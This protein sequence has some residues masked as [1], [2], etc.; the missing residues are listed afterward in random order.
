MT[1]RQLPKLKDFLPLLQPNPIIWDPTERRLSKA[2]KIE[3]LRLIAKRRTPKAIFEYVDGGSEYEAT[4]RK[5]RYLFRQL[6]LVP[7]VMV[8]VENVDTTRQILGKP[9][10][11]PWVF[12]PTG[13]TR[14]MHH[15][16]EIAVA[17][18]AER[19]GVP[20]G[21][22]VI[23]TTLIEDVAKAAPHGRNFLGSGVPADRELGKKLFDRAKANGFEALVVYVDGATPGARLRDR[24][25]GLTIPPHPTLK[26]FVDGALHPNW[27]F[28]FFTTAPISFPNVDIPPGGSVHE[29]SSQLGN[30]AASI[31][32]FEWVV[33]EW[34]G[35]VVAK[36]MATAKDARR[37]VDAGAAGVVLSAHGGRQFDQG[38]LPLRALPSVVQEVGKEAEVFIDTGIMNAADMLAAIALGAT[39]VFVGRIYLYGL[40]AGGERGVDR[41][42]EILT[43]QMI[44]IM[45][46]MG[47]T[48]LDQLT[49]DHVILP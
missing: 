45:K 22:S 39:G 33:K 32:D 6:E 10:S 42:Q 21:L 23:S 28:N 2:H 48:S 43:E 40:M 49:P 3:D 15:E 37:L 9:A 30:P 36:G 46:L 16:G 35:P 8:D 17:R 4:L 24:Y 27:W 34:G 38:P 5:A 26:T 41:A 11:Y 44:R 7:T 18:S 31:K 1:E 47:V 19:F 29:I 14:V 20:Y 12:T 25:N 13:V